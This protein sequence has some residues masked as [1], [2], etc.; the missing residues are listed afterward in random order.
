[1]AADKFSLLAGIASDW[2]WEMDAD[3]RFTFLSE[4]F[5]D[6]L[7]PAGVDRWSAS[8][9][10]MSPRTDY[11]NPAWRA[12]LDD[13]ANRRPF[14][15]FETT[16]IDACGTS[17]PVMISGTPQFAADGTFEGY[18]GVGHDLTELRRP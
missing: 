12:H 3:L 11:D 4:R 7:R 9:A 8:G 17:R 10:P 15:N 6:D 13:L 1:M 16:V 2:W 18:I 14:R 5:A